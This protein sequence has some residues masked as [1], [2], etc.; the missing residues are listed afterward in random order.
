MLRIHTNLPKWTS[1]L[2]RFWYHHVAKTDLHGT[3]GFT[4]SYLSP[5]SVSGRATKSCKQIFRPREILKESSEKSS[6]N[7][8]SFVSKKIK[9]Y[10]VFQYYKISWFSWFLVNF[11]KAVERKMFFK[12]QVGMISEKL[13]NF[14]VL[15]YI[16]QSTAD[17]HTGGLNSWIVNTFT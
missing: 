3:V 17:N 14:G 1:I 15:R 2:T 11:L 7:F 5:W 16:P 13:K 9:N 8:G 6:L 12:G 10:F 4:S